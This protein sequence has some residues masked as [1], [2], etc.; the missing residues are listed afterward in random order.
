MAGTRRAAILLLAAL[1]VLGTGSALA[2][3]KKK[4]KKHPHYASAISLTHPSSSEFDGV[5]GSKFNPCRD[6]RVVTLFYTDP[7]TAQTQPLSVQRTTAKGRYQVLLPQPAYGGSY[8]AE[9]AVQNV[10]HKKVTSTCKAATSR[11][12]DVQGPPLTP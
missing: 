6:S 7:A 4:H 5:V 12:I 1:L 2:G 9:V 10:R 3:A 8:H 11:S